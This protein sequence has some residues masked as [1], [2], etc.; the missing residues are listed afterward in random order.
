MR[1]LSLRTGWLI[2]QGSLRQ[3]VLLFVN[4]AAFGDSAEV[5]PVLQKSFHH[6]LLEFVLL[7]AF[8]LTFQ[9]AL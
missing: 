5:R 6:V 7:A 8:F 4:E 3:L 1:E 9:T 2:S